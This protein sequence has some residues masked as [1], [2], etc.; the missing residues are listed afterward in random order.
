MSENTKNQKL[1]EVNFNFHFLFLFQRFI[2]E[3]VRWLLVNG[4]KDE[5]RE[6][7][8]KVAKVNKKEM[9]M[10]DLHVPEKTD[11]KGVLELFKTWKMAK[12]SLIQ[13]YAW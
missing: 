7:L 8:E 5:A 11:S 13:I 3:S 4:R 2:P 12:L 9:P 6:I 10:E 1:Y